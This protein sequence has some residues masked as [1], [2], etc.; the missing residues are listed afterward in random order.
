MKKQILNIA[1]LV[2]SFSTF[3]QNQTGEITYFF[4]RNAKIT[5]GNGEQTEQ[6]KAITEMLRKQFRKTF[7]LKFSGNTSIYEKKKELSEN[8]N[9]GINI[10]VFDGSEGKLY[11][12]TSEKEYVKADE[13]LGKRFLVSDK[14][15]KPNWQLI[16][17]TKKI[18]G[19][20]CYK[21]KFIKKE[22]NENDSLIKTSVIAWYTPDI[23]INNGPEIL[24]GLPGLI[25]EVHKGKVSI[26]ATKVE[27]NVKNIK[28]EKPVK[29]KKISQEEFDIIKKKHTKQMQEMYKGGRQKDNGNSIRIQIDG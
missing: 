27:I 13:S 2:L 21:A 12:S 28:I 14:L 23:P 5:I 11:K 16:D 9:G 8:T 26:T 29:G 22:T 7:I 19:Y 1:L 6:Q 24:W 15:I 25:L 4:N 3:A 17:S 10:I 20:M 18:M